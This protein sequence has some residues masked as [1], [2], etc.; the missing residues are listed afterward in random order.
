MHLLSAI[1]EME[2]KLAEKPLVLVESEI[3]VLTEKVA[4]LH[5]DD[6]T[7]YLIGTYHNREESALATERLVGIARPHIVAVELCRTS[8]ERFNLKSS[9]V[10][11]GEQPAQ[12]SFIELVPQRLRDRAIGEKLL[13]GLVTE[14]I[15]YDA[16]CQYRERAKRFAMKNPHARRFTVKPKL[17]YDVIIGQEMTV[18]FGEHCWTVLSADSQYLVN[19][20]CAYKIMLADRPIERTFCSIVSALSDDEKNVIHVYQ[21]NFLRLFVS[22]SHSKSLMLSLMEKNSRLRDAIVERRDRYIARSLRKA[23]KDATTKPNEKAR[24]VGIFGKSH[25]D[26]IIRHLHQI[27]GKDAARKTRLHKSNNIENKTLARY[28]GFYCTR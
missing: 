23:L 21:T 19:G 10:A 22:L 12:V 7:F 1:H 25:V 4:I 17:F 28:N 9:P 3:E 8:L 16:Y 2:K 13:L 15:K 11:T 27:F 18:P 20:E 5:H 24:V 14:S 26:G 6:G